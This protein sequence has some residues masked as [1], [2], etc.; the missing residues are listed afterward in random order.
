M[1]PQAILLIGAAFGGTTKRVEV[2]PFSLPATGDVSIGA[3]VTGLDASGS[4]LCEVRSVVTAEAQAHPAV[5]TATGFTASFPGL[6]AGAWVGSCDVTV[7]EGWTE[8]SLVVKMRPQYWQRLRSRA[9]RLRRLSLTVC[10][11]S[12]S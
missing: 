6:T 5:V 3:V 2:P 11:G 10:S 8:R 1:F 4:A 9:K 7:G 12:L